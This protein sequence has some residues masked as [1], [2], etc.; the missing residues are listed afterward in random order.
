MKKRLFLHALFW[1]VCL[2]V[3]CLVFAADNPAKSLF[4]RQSDPNTVKYN[5]GLSDNEVWCGSWEELKRTIDEWQRANVS[6]AVATRDAYRTGGDTRV[7]HIADVTRNALNLGPA[8]A[9]EMAKDNEASREMEFSPSDSCMPS[10]A[11]HQ[12]VEGRGLVPK[13]WNCRSEYG[14]LSPSTPHVVYRSAHG[15]EHTYDRQTGKV[16]LDGNLGTYDYAD[17][18]IHPL[19]HHTMEVGPWNDSPK[20]DAKK[21]MF[22]GIFWETD[23][24]NP[25]LFYLVDANTGQRLTRKEVREA[26]ATINTQFEQCWV[27]ERYQKQTMTEEE[28]Q[29]LGLEWQNKENPATLPEVAVQ[30]ATPAYQTQTIDIDYT[31]YKSQLS[32]MLEGTYQYCSGIA[33]EEGFGAE[34]QSAVAPVM[35][36]GRSA[37]SSIPDRETFTIPVQ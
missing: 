21:M 31:A 3:P 12:G 24:R 14:W 36:Q 18:S 32:G 5:R 6:D 26:P 19:D 11:F 13:M 7:S 16:V 20:D 4:G 27:N 25:N 15:P 8:S 33:A 22:A 35:N 30:N 28:R 1:G 23:S 2:S 29:S 37:I 9:D 17:A 34:Y 10:D